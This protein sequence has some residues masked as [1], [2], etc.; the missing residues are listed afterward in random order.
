MSEVSKYLVHIVFV[1]GAEVKFLASHVSLSED[2]LRYHFRSDPG[3]NHFTV[4]EPV[5]KS[6]IAYIS[7]S[8]ASI[9]AKTQE[10]NDA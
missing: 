5:A 6:D 1:G 8:S 9:H 2:S 3:Q 7:I 10:S 4:L